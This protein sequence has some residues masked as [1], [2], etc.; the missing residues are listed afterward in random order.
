[1]VDNIYHDV[2]REEAD[3]RA[4]ALRPHS[5]ASFHAKTRSPAAWRKIP[6]AYLVCE[7]DKLIPATLQEGMVDNMRKA[8][9]DVSVE[10]VASSHS[11]YLSRPVE[12]A[13]FLRRA[14]GELFND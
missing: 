6:V 1:M 10:R 9:A 14:A 5:L 8:G 3:E 11:P 2:P 4:A 12:V 13:R 7:D